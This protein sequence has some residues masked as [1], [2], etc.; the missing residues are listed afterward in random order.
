MW[1]CSPPRHEARRI[2]CS[3]PQVNQIL[4]VGSRQEGARKYSALDKWAA[5]IGSLHAAV[6]NKLVTHVA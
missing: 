1:A 3:A 4:E 5:Q 2:P 6:Q